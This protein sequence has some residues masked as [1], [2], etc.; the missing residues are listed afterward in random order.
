MSGLSAKERE[1]LK[2]VQSGS[3][4]AVRAL[5]NAGYSPNIAARR[6][7]ITPLH[8]AVIQGDMLMIKALVGGGAQLNVPDRRGDFPLDTAIYE[9]RDAAAKYLRSQGARRHDEDDLTGGVDDDASDGEIDAEDDENQMS[10]P[11]GNVPAAGNENVQHDFAESAREILAAHIDTLGADTY[12]LPPR[13]KRG[14]A[15][16]K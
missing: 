10:P 8:E 16:P 1:F 4:G 3:V 13:A 9:D 14:G 2:A 5:L 15:S 11:A 7:D 6:P 12:R